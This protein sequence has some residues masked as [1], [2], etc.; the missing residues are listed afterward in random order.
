MSELRL[1]VVTKEWVIIAPERGS[2]PR[3]IKPLASVRP[4]LPVHDPGCPFCP[5]NERET[6]TEVFRLGNGDGADWATRVV[7]NRYPVLSREHVSPD[8]K[9]HGLRHSLQGFGVHEVIIDTPR[10]DIATAVMPRSQ[11]E[12]LFLTY[13]ARYRACVEDERIGHVVIFKNHGLAAGTSLIHPHS[14]VVATSVV[15]YQVRDRIRTLED[16]DA[17]YGQCVLCQMIDQ[18]ATE[19]VRVIHINDS[20]VAFVPYAAL[21]PF[22]VWVF[23]L[24]HM[25]QYG[26]LTDDEVKDLAETMHI[27]LGKLYFGLGDPDFNFV[28]RS[29]PRTCPASA[30]H[31]YLSIVPR[32]GRTAGFELGSGMYVNDRAPEEAAEF[33]QSVEVPAE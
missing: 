1:N 27:V 2:R 3:E 18:E 23:P 32:L 22:H 28:I 9:H 29:A 24:R 25:A 6:E 14:Q 11:I 33:L 31:W 13:R 20:F 17:L 7:L 21:S 5:G 26:E 16:H 10:H 4:P 30:F 8:Q 12:T 19:G 15:S